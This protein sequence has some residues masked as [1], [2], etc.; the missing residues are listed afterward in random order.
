MSGAAFGRACAGVTCRML[1]NATTVSSVYNNSYN[2]TM[3]DTGMPGNND[4][5]QQLGRGS[6]VAEKLQRYGGEA[7]GG[8]LGMRISENM[9]S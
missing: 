7:G 4:N 8:H 2:K 1:G 5:P 3:M 9:M 6:D